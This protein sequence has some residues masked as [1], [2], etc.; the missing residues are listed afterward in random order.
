MDNVEKPKKIALATKENPYFL[1][2]NFYTYDNKVYEFKTY[3]NQKI[4]VPEADPLT[5][6]NVAGIKADKKHVFCN[7][8]SSNSPPK[9]ITVNGFS[10]NNPNAIWE[11]EIEKGVDG[12]SFNYI[13]ERC[14][15]IFWRDNHSV[16]IMILR[17]FSITKTKHLLTPRLLGF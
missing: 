15:T 5:F 6:R 12:S 13:K 2:D 17:I 11:W 9:S 8:L 7:K 10:K 14:D 1:F 3:T 16:F 4:V